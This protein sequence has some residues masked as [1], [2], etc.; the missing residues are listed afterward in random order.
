M[1][2]RVYNGGTYDL[3]HQGHLYVFG[4]MRRLAGEGGKVI[5]G[6]NTDDFVSEF[7]GHPPVQSYED[8]AA[9]LSGLRDVDIVIPNVGGPDAKPAILRARPNVIAVGRDWWSR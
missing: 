4:Q 5:I 8:R 3:L 1:G 9:V 2:L 6:L 7:K